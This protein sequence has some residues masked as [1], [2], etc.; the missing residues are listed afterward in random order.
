MI[1]IE[2][3]PVGVQRVTVGGDNPL[4]QATTCFE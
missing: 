4:D 2:I 3:T 1:H